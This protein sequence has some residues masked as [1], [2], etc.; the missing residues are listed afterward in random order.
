MVVRNNTFTLEKELKPKVINELVIGDVF[1]ISN[2]KS[3][4]HAMLVVDVAKNPKT[5]DKIFL[6]AQSYMPAQDIHVVKNP[7]IPQNLGWFSLQSLQNQLQTP[8]WVFPLRA[9]REFE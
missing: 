3:Y 4:G 5:Q 6:L 2:P 8:E 9:L 1:I 7:L